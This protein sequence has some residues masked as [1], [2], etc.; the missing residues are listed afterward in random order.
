MAGRYLV[1]GGVS[2][3]KQEAIASIRIDTWGN[4]RLE[5]HARDHQCHRRS[6]IGRCP[7]FPDVRTE[8]P[9]SNTIGRSVAVIGGG[10]VG[11]AV[12][13]DLGLRFPG[14]A[15]T[16]IEKEPDVARHQSGHNSGVVHAGLYDKPGS[17]RRRFVVV[18]V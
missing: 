5:R 14:L 10:I 18:A 8:P 4:E 13:R 12:A 16:V 15:V 3:T 17:Q 2:S 7:R 11:L 1:G 9:M 6:V